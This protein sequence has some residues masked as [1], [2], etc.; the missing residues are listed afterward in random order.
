MIRI[1]Q[2]LI[3]GAAAIAG[4]EPS[5]HTKFAGTATNANPVVV[6]DGPNQGAII[7]GVASNPLFVTST[8]EADGG[9]ASTVTVSGVAQ[10]DTTPGDLKST[11]VPWTVA[12]S[13]GLIADAGTVSFV[14]AVVQNEG[15]LT[16]WWQLFC[17]QTTL[18]AGGLANSGLTPTISMRCP[19][20]SYCVDPDEPQPCAGGMAWYSSS[21]QGLVTVDAGTQAMGVHLVI[22]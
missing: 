6:V 2:C 20:G 3:L 19:A 10:V 18:D 21:T 4:C 12:T 15:T 11:V 7:L 13:A 14:K 9:G 22:R 16:A 17:G 8:G 5:P 1:I